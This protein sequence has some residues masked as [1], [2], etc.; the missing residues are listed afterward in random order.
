MLVQYNS[1][2]ST[3]Q[4]LNLS[5][6]ETF[7]ERITAIQ[8]NTISSTTRSQNIPQDDTSVE[9]TSH[10]LDIQVNNISSTMPFED[11]R[12]INAIMVLINGFNYESD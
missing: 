11:A 2:S 7:I 1:I 5:Q 3:T 4:S 12:V 8:D 6:N 10:H 9:R